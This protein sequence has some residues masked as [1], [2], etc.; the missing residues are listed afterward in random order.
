MLESAAVFVKNSVIHLI[1]T[2]TESSAIALM[3]KPQV[4]FFCTQSVGLIQNFYVPPNS[5]RSLLSYS[6]ATSHVSEFNFSLCLLRFFNFCQ[7]KKY[8]NFYSLWILLSRKENRLKCVKLS[9]IWI[10]HLRENGRWL[11]SL[12]FCTILL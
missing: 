4:I 7:R 1:S 9:V 3:V 12:G 5:A 11:E 10:R 8:T 2:K 6:P